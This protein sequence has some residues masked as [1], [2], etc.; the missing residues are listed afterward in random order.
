MERRWKRVA[1]LAAGILMGAAM[2]GTP[3]GGHVTTSVSHIWKHIRPKADVR[4]VNVGESL[5]A[6]VNSN[7][8][9]ARGGGVAAIDPAGTGYTE[10]YFRRNVTDCA[11][12]GTIGLASNSGIEAAGFI[13]VVGTVNDGPGGI[14]NENGVW[15]STYDTG[16]SLADR[17]FHLTVDCAK[18]PS[19][20]TEVGP[21]LGPSARRG[22][23]AR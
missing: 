11:F 5:W 3:V 1:L 4:Y 12:T 2:V 6:V 15:V 10:V 16:G 17:G 14:P 13:T 20:A 7:N 22:Q 18:F 23:N 8:T 9:L 19:L 21:A